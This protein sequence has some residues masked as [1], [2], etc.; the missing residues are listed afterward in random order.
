MPIAYEKI[1]KREHVP[2]GEDGISK[3]LITTDDCGPCVFFLVDCVF[4]GK[5]IC[6]LKHYDFK[7]IDDSNMSQLECFMAFLSIISTDLKHHI[8]IKSIRP[9]DLDGKTGHHDCRLTIGGGDAHTQ[10]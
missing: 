7:E 2:Q 5:K 1:S 8:D 3:K 9:H 6:Y 10:F 4:Q